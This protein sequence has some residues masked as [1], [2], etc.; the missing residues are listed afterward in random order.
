[1]AEQHDTPQEVARRRVFYIP[2]YDPIHPRRYRELYR[3]EGAAQAAISGYALTL[4][5]KQGGGAYGWHVQTVM[6]GAET[7]ADIEVL[8]W[9]DIVRDSMSNSI[10]ATYTQ[11]VRTSWEYIATGALR[12]LMRLRKG[13]V[14]AALY[15]VGALLV[16]LG[17]ALLLGWAG[18]ALIGLLTPW[19]GIAATLAGLVAWGG[20]AY[21]ALRWFRAK[22]GKFFAYYLMHDYAFSALHRGANPPALEARMSEFAATI[23]AAL[24]EDVDEVLVVGHSSGAHLAVSI[25]ADL[26]R[27][28][29]V[30]ANGPRLAF[31]SL[32]QVVPM[33]SFL[34]EAHRLR[35][36]LRFLSASEALTWVDVTAPGDGCAFALCDPV[37]VSGVAPKDKRWPLVF[38]AQFT[39][40]LSPERWKE[41]RWRFFRLHFQYLCAF[42]RPRDYDY[43]RITAGPLSLASRYAGRP[44]SASRIDHAVSKYTSVAA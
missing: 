35:A 22:D 20:I 9:S 3:K 36:D 7:R 14:I 18:F 42:D 34:R 8:V 25:L 11:L 30:P 44:P 12:R 39:R 23:G 31:L 17:L 32:G 29:R 27:A 19:L 33:V 43:F 41:L 37:G 10:P 40:S 1:M 15:P 13:P 28:G 21:A 4:R 2:G 26:I 24:T 38:S 5:P 6:E 16:Q